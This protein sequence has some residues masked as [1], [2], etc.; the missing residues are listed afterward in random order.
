MF[1]SKKA[2]NQTDF[3]GLFTL[4]MKRNHFSLLSLVGSGHSDL[5]LRYPSLN[6]LPSAQYNE[7]ELNFVCGA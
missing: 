6:F 1:S 2:N 4:R 7:G 5:V 3:K